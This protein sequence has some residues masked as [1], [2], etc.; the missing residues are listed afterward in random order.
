VTRPR[1][2]SRRASVARLQRGGS[3]KASAAARPDRTQPVA[4]P[5]AIT[6]S[7]IAVSGSPVVPATM[8]AAIAA[9]ALKR[10]A[11]TTAEGEREPR[12]EGRRGE[13]LEAMCVV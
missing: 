9:V 10:S 13:R 2:R 6:A 12:S 3:A 7:T 5:V 1:L 4:N 8:V 11:V